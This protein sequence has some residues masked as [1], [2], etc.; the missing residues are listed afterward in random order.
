MVSAVGIE[1]STFPDRNIE[2]EEPSRFVAKE[3]AVG[4]QGSA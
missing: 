1:P 3:R 4:V 2:L